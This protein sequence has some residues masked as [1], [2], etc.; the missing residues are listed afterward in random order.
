MATKTKTNKT[1]KKASNTKAMAGV[2]A[3][4]S[5]MQTIVLNGQQY[6]PATLK[7]VF[8]ADNTAIDA[9][10]SAHKALAQSVLDERNSNASTA[11]VK[12]ALRSFVLGYFGQEAVAIIGDFGMNVPK[13]RATKTVATKA[14]AAVKAKATRAARG[15]VGSVQKLNVTGGVTGAVISETG[16]GAVLTPHT[17]AGTLPVATAPAA[18]AAASAE[19]AP[20]VTPG[21]TPT[22]ATGAAT[23]AP[24]VTAAPPVAAPKA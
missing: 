8:Q 15:V 1:D 12:R 17:A 24:A 11:K 9:A 14:L 10:D 21:A 4:L 18:S 22:A 6:T 2:D 5:G 13:P 23:A 3:H 16:A 20:A 7:G 19:P